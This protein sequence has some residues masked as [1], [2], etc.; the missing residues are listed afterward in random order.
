MLIKNGADIE[1]AMKNDM[2]NLNAASYNGIVLFFSIVYINT[3]YRVYILNKN[4]NKCHLGKDLLV[5]FLLK[6]GSDPNS[7]LHG[8]RS[9]LHEAARWGNALHII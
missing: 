9:P 3:G 1:L 8:E 6:D 4:C 5:E 7:L 2:M